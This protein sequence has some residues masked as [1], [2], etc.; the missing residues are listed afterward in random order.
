MVDMEA[1]CQF[2][3]F[4][5]R[6]AGIDPFRQLTDPLFSQRNILKPLADGA[7]FCRSDLSHHNRM[8]LISSV[9]PDIFSYFV[10]DRLRN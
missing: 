1:L 5:L 7:A 3:C 2:S 10:A 9:F 8:Y 6:Q 4:F